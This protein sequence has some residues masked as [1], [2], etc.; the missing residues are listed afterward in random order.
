ML[1][2]NAPASHLVWL[3]CSTSVAPTANWWLFMSPAPGLFPVCEMAFSFFLWVGLHA[4][5]RLLR[6]EAFAELAFWVEAFAKIHFSAR[7]FPPRLPRP[8]PPPPLDSAAHVPSLLGPVWAGGGQW[9]GS[10]SQRRLPE[11]RVLEHGH[12]S[13]TKHV[14]KVT[15][16]REKGLGQATEAQAC[17]WECMVGRSVRCL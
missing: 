4:R 13:A 6:I 17:S 11:E 9:G 12:G 5:E 3:C 7:L 16:G 2:R 14:R 10:N 15:Q 1:P 8:R